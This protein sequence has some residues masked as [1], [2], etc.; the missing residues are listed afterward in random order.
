M[1]G[2]A[3]IPAREPERSGGPRFGIRAR[4]MS[5]ATMLVL[6]TVVLTGLLV[7]HGATLALLNA[8]RKMLASDTQSISQEFDRFIDNMRRDTLFASRLPAIVEFA[9]EACA[10]AAEEQFYRCRNHATGV[11]SS[12]LRARQ[13][14]HQIAIVAADGRELLRIHTDEGPDF[15]AP[16]PETQLRSHLD[17]PEFRAATALPEGRTWISDARIESDQNLDPSRPRTL[18]AAATPLHRANGQLFGFM[19]LEADLHK[20][21]VAQDDK[22]GQSM[23]LYLSNSSGDLLYASDGT[24]SGE[25][26]AEFPQLGPAVGNPGKNTL[27]TIDSRGAKQVLASAFVALQAEEPERQLRVTVAIPYALIRASVEPSLLEISGVFG[28]AILLTLPIAFIATGRVVRPLLRMSAAVA[29]YQPGES[30]AGLPAARTDEIGQL[31]RAFADM[32][33]RLSGS[34]ARQRAA[35]ETMLDAHVVADSQRRI[36]SFNPAAERTFGYQAS[37]VLGTLVSTLLP[38]PSQ[39]RHADDYARYQQGEDTGVIDRVREVHARRK[40]GEI[41]PIELMLSTFTVDGEQLFSAVMRDISARRKA[42]EHLSHLAAAIESAD[43]CMEIL[44]PTGEIIYINP[45]YERANKCTLADVIGKRPDSL[46]DFDNEDG[47]VT[48]LRAAAQSG[49]KWHG[50]LR[51]RNPGGDSFVE[52]V[53]LSPIHNGDGVLSAFVVVKRD[54]SEKLEMEQQLLRGQKLEAVGQLAAGIAH[55]INTPTQYVGDNI[56]FLKE[57]F[58]EVGA[59]LRH[60][61]E[62]SQNT[63]GA[64]L[65]ADIGK[66][67]EDA[68]ADYLLAEI[69][70]AINQS[71]DGVSRVAGIVRAMKDFSHPATERTPLDINRAMASTATVASNEWKYVAELRTDFDTELPQVPVMPGD[72]NQV[73]L[74]MIVNAAHAIGDV[75][76]DSAS[77]RG[78]ITLSTR[79]LDDWAEI[80]I[81]D[82]GCGMTPEV[83]AR[84]FDP[85]FT[86][87]AVGKGTGQ[88]LAIT[89]N[90][91]VEKHGG[92]ITVESRP[93]AGSTF[94]IRLPLEVPDSSEQAEHGVRVA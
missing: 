2:S 75:V 71:L 79:K 51:S 85:F 45:A 12:L 70:T 1:N 35:I 49:T 78:T 47:Q 87:K 42:E 40:S 17:S 50:I 58:A 11:L 8:H 93:G 31:A 10:A 3:D 28:L 86:T 38:V 22:A 30:L 77:G 88:G 24:H 61:K 65:P 19:L 66:A 46:R 62:I 32:V 48:A 90:V 9:S 16:V 13:D 14:Y 72:F 94:I 69:P 73:I 7:F 60:L 83:A 41:F 68:D 82:T 57:S 25:L 43:E 53:S 55:E 6:L 81:S 92:T 63:G 34:E 4:A 64:I 21:S 18:I 36:V 89:Y 59:L 52:D 33:R 37:E 5:V 23:L 74:N 56:R 39:T 15:A 44:S 67:L 54:I 26:D 20:L 80:R 76:G 29:G 27:V 91:I 84:I